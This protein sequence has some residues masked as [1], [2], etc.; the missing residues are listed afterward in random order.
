MYEKF[1]RNKVASLRII[2]AHENTVWVTI[3]ENKDNERDLIKLEECIISKSYLDY[4]NQKLICE[5]KL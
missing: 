1:F 5:D 2:F 3:H 4:T